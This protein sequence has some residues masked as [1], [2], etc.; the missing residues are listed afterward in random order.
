MKKICP[1]LTAWFFRGHLRG[2]ASVTGMKRHLVEFGTVLEF[3]HLHES[4][5]HTANRI[6]RRSG[7]GR[8]G[9]KGKK[10]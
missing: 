1:A 10:P 7:K 5:A 8:K 9:S 6:R 4:R 3:R 2:I